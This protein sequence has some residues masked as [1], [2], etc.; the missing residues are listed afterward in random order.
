MRK[1]KKVVVVFLALTKKHL[2]TKRIK[3]IS[4]KKIEHDFNPLAENFAFSVFFPEIQEQVHKVKNLGQP[5][6]FTNKTID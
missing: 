6:K 5:V 3:F 2:G 4:K 1:W